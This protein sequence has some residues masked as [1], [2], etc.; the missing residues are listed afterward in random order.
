MK[1]S[2]L[3]VMAELVPP[4]DPPETVTVLAISQSDDDHRVLREILGHSRWKFVEAR[5]W[6]DGLRWL[7][8][9]PVM[10]L[11][12]EARGPEGHWTGLLERLDACQKRP[13]V[14]V[15]SPVPDDY[16]WA[17][18]L[19]RGAA[20]VLA[21]PFDSTEVLRAIPAAVRHTLNLRHHEVRTVVASA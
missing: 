5:T 1:H 18:A 8:D 15:T 20:D 14:I 11:L 13:P 2:G 17:E 16:L 4:K 9:H 7:R 10:V 12:C 6:A 3:A 19:N 21:K